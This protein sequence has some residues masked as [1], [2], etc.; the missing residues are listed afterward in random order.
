M[1][2]EA[3]QHAKSALS[4]QIKLCCDLK[5]LLT[6]HRFKYMEFFR[7][8]DTNAIFESEMINVTTSLD[9]SIYIHLS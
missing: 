6:I 8:K 9:A 4:K 2:L 7:A 5:R 3:V 1:F